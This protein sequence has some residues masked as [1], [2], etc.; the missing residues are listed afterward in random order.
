MAILDRK[1]WK[2]YAAILVIGG[3]AGSPAVIQTS[4]GKVHITY[5]WKREKIKH[6]VIEL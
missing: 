2:T 3:I 4:D 1:S 6:V 5:T